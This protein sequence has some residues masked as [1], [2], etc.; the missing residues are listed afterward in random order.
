[1]L[2]A[3]RELRMNSR[4]LAAQQD[5]YSLSS[6]VVAMMIQEIT[7]QMGALHSVID[8]LAIVDLVSSFANVAQGEKF[9]MSKLTTRAI[10]HPARV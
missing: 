10:I 4:I 7:V 5:I 6:Q 2:L 3:D 9:S 1:M 8:A